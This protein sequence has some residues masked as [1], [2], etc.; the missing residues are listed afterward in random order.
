MDLLDQIS[1]ANEDVDLYAL[2]EQIVLAR[3]EAGKKAVAEGKGFNQRKDAQQ[4][5]EDKILQKYSGDLAE[6][7]ALS[8]L[9]IETY[10][11]IKFA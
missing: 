10:E 1:R 8:R 6:R 2:G 9:A 7:K 11:N 3:D 5:A 4:D